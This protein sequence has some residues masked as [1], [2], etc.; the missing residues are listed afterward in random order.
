[1]FKN[2]APAT[3]LPQSLSR[4]FV[5]K[6]RFTVFRAS[7]DSVI[8]VPLACVLFSGL[9]DPSHCTTLA[10]A[11]KL[12]AYLLGVDKS[13]RRFDIHEIKEAPAAAQPA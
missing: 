4:T 8:T 3:V 9:P 6:R 12:V 1:M 10:V 7:Y 5:H 11:R 2:A 13:G